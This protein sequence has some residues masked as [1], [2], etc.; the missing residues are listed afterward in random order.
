MMH[1]MRAEVCTV[2]GF[3]E[4][5]LKYQLCEANTRP[6]PISPKTYAMIEQIIQVMGDGNLTVD[7]YVKNVLQGKLC[8]ANE[9]QCITP[10]A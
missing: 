2:D 4:S 5:A 3:V 7:D 1:V 6:I 9:A 8:E 10:K